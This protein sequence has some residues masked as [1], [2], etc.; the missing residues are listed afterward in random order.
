MDI[1]Q[2]A[3][4]NWSQFKGKVKERW[5]QLTDDEL[6][7]V[8]GNSD[9]LI[10][11]IQQKTGEAREQ[12]ERVL[13]QFSEHSGGVGSNAAETARQYADQASEMVR[14]AAEEFR[15]QAG[16][17]YGDAQAM[18]RARPAEA[19]AV[20]FGTGVVVGVI[21]GLV[22]FHVPRSK[23]RGLYDSLTAEGVG[24]RLLERAESILPEAL[25]DRLGI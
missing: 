3:I 2:Q 12:I 13:T 23:K 24:R 5:G 11:L 9:Q 10:G 14:G 8:E 18:V 21:L 1:Q 6:M 19:I 22:A 16:E 20:A 7:E 4:G 25:A 15:Y 17:R